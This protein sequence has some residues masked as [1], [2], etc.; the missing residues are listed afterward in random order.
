MAM[1]DW[2]TRQSGTPKAL[3]PDQ[4]DAVVPKPFPKKRRKKKDQL[5]KQMDRIPADNED[6]RQ[7]LERLAKWKT[8]ADC[9]EKVR[10]DWETTYEVE[11]CEQYFL[12]QQWDRGVRRQDLVLNHFLATVRVMKPNLLYGIPKFFVRPKP[13][14]RQPVGELRAAMGEGVLEFIAGQDHN[15]K[16]SGKLALLQAFFRVGCLKMVYDPRMEPNPRK[17]ELLYATDEEGVAMTDENGGP[18]VMHDPLTGEPMTEPEAVLTDEVY[19]FEYVDTRHLLLPDEGADSSRWTWIG[20]RVMLPLAEAKTDPRFPMALRD[21]FESNVSADTLM[22]G[23]YSHL[24]AVKDDELFQYTEVY[25][26]I[27]KRLIIWAEGQSF[28]DFLVDDPLPH[29]IEDDPYSLL[30]MGDPILGPTPCPWPAPFTHPW[31]EPQREYNISR[32]QI[33][34]GGKRSARK[35]VYDDGT[36]PDQ[37]AAVQFLQ[38]PSD[39]LGVKVNDVLRPPLVIPCPDINPA[40]YKNVPMMQTDWRIITGQTGARMS[41]PEGGTA[42]EASFVERAANLRDADTQDMVNDWLSE[43]GRKMLQLVKGTLTLGLWVKMRSFSDKD[44]LKYAERYWGIP[45]ERTMVFLDTMPQL[46]PMLMARFGDERFEMV[47]RESLTFEA[48]VT[49]APGSMRPRNLDV[50]RQNWLEF[51]KIIGQFP[52]LLMSRALLGTTAAKF[53]TIDERMLDELHELGKA[54]MQQQNEVAGRAQGGA[55]NGGG[56][57]SSTAGAP[58]LGALVAGVQAGLG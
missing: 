29:G 27:G 19:R 4:T 56:A 32:Q 21:Q 49:V 35:V 57:G 5:L 51:L 40:I 9:A 50:E 17:G 54:M 36:F 18:Q 7:R 46:K 53:E 14:R 44:F 2:F 6:A 11:R 55:V 10:K 8:R 41:S 34:E 48:E 1:K 37:D 30:I 15:L 52:Q 58:D 28:E 39:M 47:T 33:V 13:G 23:S 43:C 45:Q 16:R 26:R 3:P 20:E 31:L 12:G 22:A 25:D 24:R 42:T 38:D